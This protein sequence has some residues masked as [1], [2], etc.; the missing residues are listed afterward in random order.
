MLSPRPE[1]NITT[2]NASLSN[3]IELSSRC[4]LTHDKQLSY[5]YVGIVLLVKLLQSM[6]Y[7]LVAEHNVAI[8]THPNNYTTSSKP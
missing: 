3:G 8:L 7:I 4:K 1:M 6:P 2:A 5:D